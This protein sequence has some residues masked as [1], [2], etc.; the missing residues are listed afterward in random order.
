MI[1]PMHAITSMEGRLR[2]SMKQRILA[3]H[4]KLILFQLSHGDPTTHKNVK[5]DA[6][7]I[8]AVP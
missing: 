5:S 6:V 4:S 2:F 1:G 3:F 7:T 8:T